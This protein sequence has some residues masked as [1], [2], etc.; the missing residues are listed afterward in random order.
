[1]PEEFGKLT[2]T[3]DKAAI[4]KIIADGRIAE[5]TNTLAELAREQIPAQVVDHL[6]R[7]TQ[8]GREAGTAVDFALV[9]DEG[10]GFGTRPH[11]PIGPH[12]PVVSLG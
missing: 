6:V 10:G 2:L 4:D 3:I 9:V 8:E 12:G 7:A 1:M 5:F 11:L